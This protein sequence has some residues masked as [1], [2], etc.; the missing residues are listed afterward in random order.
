MKFQ[1]NLI[2][3]VCLTCFSNSVLAQN[4][5]GHT[6]DN[7]AGIQSVIYNPATGVDSKMKLDINIFSTSAFAASDY[8]GIKLKNL[9]DSG[10]TFDTDEDTKTFPKNNNNFYVNL[11]IMLPSVMLNIDDNNSI[12][13][14]SRVRTFGNIN[15]INGELFENYENEF[16]DT[17]DFSFENDEFT[18]TIHAWAEVGLSYGRVLY[19]ENNHKIKGGI[20]LKYLQGL[21]AAFMSTNG[22]QGNYTASENTLATTGNLVYG[23]TGDFDSDD[24][25]YEDLGSGFGADIGVIYQWNNAQ[26]TDTNLKT[27][28]KLK[29]GLSVT[30]IGSISYDDTEI[31]DYDLNETINPNGNDVDDLDDLY[32]Y[33]SEIKTVKIKLP[34]AIH[35]FADYNITNRFYVSA[36]A[37][38]SVVKPDNSQTS[39]SLNTFIVTPRLESKWFSMYMPFG[40]RQYEDFGV[41]LGLRAGPLTIGSSSL[42]SNL[43]SDSSK[44]AD[45]YIGL[46]VPIYR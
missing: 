29:L 43:V 5:I 36:Q 21:G 16:D 38:I 11:D 22:M 19:N 27:D 31:S 12:A 9:F 3:I 35:L 6:V 34:T 37:D 45:V 42:I 28:Y 40:F 25:K 46:K 7:Y 4:Y 26:T 41:G 30:D 2:I 14:I 39:N 23:V 10:N 32:D 20:T 1:Y 8:Y 15:K 44:S 24:I 17:E 13:L 18:G 33:T